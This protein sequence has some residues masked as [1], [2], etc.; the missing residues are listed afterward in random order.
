MP[1]WSNWAKTVTCRPAQIA[2]PRSIDEIAAVVSASAAA[3]RPVRAVGSGH[4]YSPLVA[5][6]GTI[7]S[8]DNFQGIEAVDTVAGEVTVRGGTKLRSIGPLLRRH[9]LAMENLGDTDAQS[10][11]GAISTGTHGSGIALGSVSTQVAGLTLVTATGDVIECSRERDEDVF[12]AAAVSLG[13]LGIIARVR[14]KTVPAYRLERKKQNRQLD[15]VLAEIDSLVTDNRHFEFWAFPYARRVSTRMSNM[16]GEEPNVATLKRLW[17]N[18]VVDTAGLWVLSQAGRL[19]PAVS[20][21]VARLSARLNSQGT[22]VDDNYRILATPRYVKLTETEYAVPAEAG[23]ECL[24]EVLEFIER[25]GI[26]VNFP[27]EYRYVAADDLFLSPFYERDSALIDAQQFHGMP[28]EGYF[29]GC[30]A[31]FRKYGGRPHLGKIHHCDHSQLQALFPG[32]DDFNRVRRQL[33]PGGVFMTP[34]LR[35]L[36]GD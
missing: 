20:R 9:G 27:L 21:G 10:L 1:G 13:T 5:T 22:S 11:A 3:G 15:E 4:S 18:I 31:I 17:E 2:K 34:Y 24:R 30:E 28:Y 7:L 14:L 25:E 29:R 6:E 35:G 12:R 33:D 8:L 32:W 23:P 26:P 19:S 36:L 16:T